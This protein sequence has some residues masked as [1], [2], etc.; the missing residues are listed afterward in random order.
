MR[1]P[2]INSALLAIGVEL[3]LALD[4]VISAERPFIL[5]NSVSLSLIAR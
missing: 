2:A 4:E 3:T 5:F 1:V